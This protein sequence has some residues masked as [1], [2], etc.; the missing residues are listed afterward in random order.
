M[1]KIKVIACAALGV[2]LA[3]AIHAVEPTWVY[4]VEVS[5]TVQ[6]SPPQITLSWPRDTT[7]A[8]N[9]YVVYR[10]SKDATSW[11]SGTTLAGTTTRYADNNVSA[12]SAYEYQIVKN[13]SAYNGYG[14]IY[15]GINA[16]LTDSRGK[17]VLVVDNTH[18]GDLTNELARLAQDL[19]GDG[20]TVL[21]HDVSRNDSVPSV[22]AVIQSDYNADPANVKAVFLFGHVPVPYSGDIA[23]DGHAPNHQG[24][25]PADVYYGNMSGTWTD[26]SVNDSGAANA[27][28]HNVPGD[29]KFDQ[30]TIPT[31]VEL[32]VG[33]VDLADMPG[34]LV[35][36]GP[37]TFPGELDL[38]RN[39]LNKDHQFRFNRMTLPQRGIVGDYFGVRNGEAFAASGWRNFAPYFGAANIDSPPNEGTWIP[40]LSTNGYLW[41][42]G[43][44]AGSFTSIGGL[45][46]T[47][48]YNDGITT[49][50]VQADIKAVFTLLFGS[51]LGDW[52]SEDNIMRAVLATSSY[53][54]TCGW[55]GRPHWFLHHMALGET[56]GY[57]VRLTQ[58]NS[59][60]GLYQNQ[61]NNGVGLIHIALM[62]DPT[63]RM[64]PVS[65][66]TGLSATPDSN[67]VNLGWTASTDS[68]VGYHVYHAANPA[69]Q[70]TRLTSSP[71]NGTGYTDAGGTS[72][73]YMVRAVKL[74]TSAS[75]TYFNPSQGA[76]VVVGGSSGGTTNPP[77]AT[78]TNAPPTTNTP[79]SLTGT[80]TSSA[81]GTF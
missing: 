44:G 55:S 38:L 11:G 8:P 58:N 64:H 17:V 23:P 74:E 5:A 21:R 78:T 26:S 76:F 77:P 42:Y 40:T 39:Y 9:N 31:T 2:L 22:K 15:A 54:L 56:I 14:Y 60:G 18:A 20:W 79:P 57:G 67:G 66:I 61:L 65:P 33:R 34:R 4:S 25:W 62:G 81:T 7:T 12:G 1:R 51:W 19:T 36:N 24:A 70:F 72:G 6:T 68:V 80:N 13:T 52:D 16:P 27:R 46:N 43:C 41:A 32:M 10:K 73:T 53:S 50:L 63:L 71:M 59:Q 29:G 75:G 3:H 48:Q 69:G 45:G 35:W 28:N 30:S 49:E 37:A 47:G